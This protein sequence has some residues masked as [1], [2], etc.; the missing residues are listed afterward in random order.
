[1]SKYR[2]DRLI[3]AAGLNEPTDNPT[4]QVFADRVDDLCFLASLADGEGHSR[5]PRTEPWEPGYNQSRY[6]YR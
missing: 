2:Q 5:S 4:E 3:E 1:M 6:R